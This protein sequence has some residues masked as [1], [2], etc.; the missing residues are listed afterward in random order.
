MADSHYILRLKQTNH[1]GLVHSANQAYECN[2]GKDKSAV[3]WVLSGCLALANLIRQ[4]R[5]APFPFHSLE[6]QPLRQ[7]FKSLHCP[8][9]VFT[10]L[11]ES[12]I[13]S[14]MEC[15]LFMLGYWTVYDITCCYCESMVLSLTFRLLLKQQVWYQK[16]SG[17]VTEGNS[18]NGLDWRYGILVWE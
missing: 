7:I 9:F 11:L 1:F 15:I 13:P 3:N 18:W 2:S 14:S 6:L 12:R 16:C 5:A 4:Q 8:V 10:W 17:K